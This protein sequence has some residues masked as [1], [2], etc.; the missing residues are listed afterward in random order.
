MFAQLIMVLGL[1]TTAAFIGI[2]GQSVY[3]E[4]V[5]EDEQ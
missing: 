3:D 4:L 2:V 1:G 5:E